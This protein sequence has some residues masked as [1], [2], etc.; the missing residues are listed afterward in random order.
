MSQDLKDFKT[1]SL[2]KHEKKATRR[3]EE[4]QLEI[5]KRESGLKFGMVKCLS[6]GGYTCKE[7]AAAVELPST[8]IHRVLSAERTASRHLEPV[9]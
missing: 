5:K 2:Y 8:Y 4:I 3:L 1:S 6:D 9:D 7:I